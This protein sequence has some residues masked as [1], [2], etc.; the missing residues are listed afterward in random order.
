M[1]SIKTVIE[2]DVFLWEQEGGFCDSEIEIRT[3][4]GATDTFAER[5]AILCEIEINCRGAPD[6]NGKLGRFRITVE[7]LDDGDSKRSTA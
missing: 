2:G 1:E 5:L 7:K 3:D 4:D 6:F